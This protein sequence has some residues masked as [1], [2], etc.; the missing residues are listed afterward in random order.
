MLYP[1]LDANLKLNLVAQLKRNT[2][3]KLKL[4]MVAKLKF[5]KVAKLKLKMVAKL[6]TPW[7]DYLC[8]NNYQAQTKKNGGD[9]PWG[10]PHGGY[11]GG[12]GGYPVGV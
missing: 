11:S 8:A 4:N 3:A 12:V 6:A 2:I 10:V 1:L 7:G 9:T 5:N